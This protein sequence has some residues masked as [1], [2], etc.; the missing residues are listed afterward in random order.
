MIGHL[1]QPS[2][3]PH[4]LLWLRLSLPGTYGWTC[5]S[6]NFH[7]LGLCYDCFF[8]LEHLDFHYCLSKFYASIEAH[9]SLHPLCKIIFF[10]P[11]I[12]GQCNMLD[13][14]LSHLTF[15]T[16]PGDGYYYEK[17]QTELFKATK[18][19]SERARNQTHE[20]SRSPHSFTV[21]VL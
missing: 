11:F 1:L 7:S 12:T 2:P 5:F 19:G 10:W 18:L 16:F 15:T 13:N 8:C 4:P 14:V 20:D 6:E 21:Y 17:A 3:I 9:L